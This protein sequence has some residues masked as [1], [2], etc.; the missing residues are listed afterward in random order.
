LFHFALCVVHIIYSFFLSFFQNSRKKK[1]SRE[2]RE[3]AIVAD[4]PI[5]KRLSSIDAFFHWFLLSIGERLT[6]VRKKKMREKRDTHTQQE[7][8]C[9][10]RK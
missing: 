6:T 7:D 5:E 1:K 10:R 3:R 4:W 2:E 8:N 9:T